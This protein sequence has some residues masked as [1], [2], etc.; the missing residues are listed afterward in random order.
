MLNPENTVTK[1][2][3]LIQSKFPSWDAATLAVFDTYLSRINPKN[4]D[5]SEVIFTK[6][7]YE[8]LIGV[9]EMRP[10]QLN[11]CIRNFMSNT[12]EIPT[13][14]GGWEN[15]CLFD[16]TKFDKNEAGEWEITLRC[17]PELKD[18]FFELKSRGY[19]KYKL[20]Y[21]LALKRKHSKL[22]YFLIKDNVYKGEWRVDLRE[23]R[24]LLGATE[25]SYEKFKEFNRTVL[26][27]SVEEINEST[28]MTVDYKKITKGKLTKGVTFRIQQKQDEVVSDSDNE[29]QELS[30]SERRELELVSEFREIMN[31]VNPV[32]EESNERISELCNLV[33]D[34]ISKMPAFIELSQG[35]REVERM[36]YY[37]AI[38]RRAKSERAKSVY[39]YLISQ[40]ERYKVEVNIW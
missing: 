31:E 8:D 20:K 14:R 7:E 35:A 19:Q 15:Y 29:V 12:V 1:S 18:L 4:P 21:S 33:Y 24:E 25:K 34:H 9:K 6:K 30:I 5:S 39:K 27:K 40:W 3:Q 37:Y 38:L 36:N 16:K 23:L 32:W 28:D 17:H 2:K 22:L 26:Q 11:K 10:S 13:E